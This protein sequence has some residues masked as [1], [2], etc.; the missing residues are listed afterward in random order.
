RTRQFIKRAYPDATINGKQIHW[1]ERRLQTIRYNLQATYAGFYQDIVTR[2]EK[3][4]LAH[5]NLE[6]FKK[7]TATQDDWELGRQEALVGIFKSRFLKRLE[8]SIAAFGISIR[9][10]LEFIKTFDEYVQDGIV[11]DA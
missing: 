5:Y 8:S 10:A 4:N 1:P 7:A 9:R 6:A 3:L 2:I 11:L